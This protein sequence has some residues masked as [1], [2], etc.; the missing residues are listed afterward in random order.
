MVGGALQDARLGLTAA[1]HLEQI[2]M[3][4]S[5]RATVYTGVSRFYGRPALGPVFTNRKKSKEAYKVAF[6]KKRLKAQRA[7]SWVL[8]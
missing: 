5:V 8:Q 4:T 2:R 6:H 3:P 1:D 7:F